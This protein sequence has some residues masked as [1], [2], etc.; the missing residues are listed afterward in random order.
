MPKFYLWQFLPMK[1]YTWYLVYLIFNLLVFKM[2]TV[3]HVLLD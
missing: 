2:E 1:S 3:A